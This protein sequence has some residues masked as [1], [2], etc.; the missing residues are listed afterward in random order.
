MAHKRIVNLL[1]LHP[2][3]SESPSSTEMARVSLSS[4]LSKPKRGLE[5]LGEVP[6]AALRQRGAEEIWRDRFAQSSGDKSG[7]FGQTDVS[8]V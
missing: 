4:L 1:V 5:N 2:I 8:Y 6:L 7:V 3:A